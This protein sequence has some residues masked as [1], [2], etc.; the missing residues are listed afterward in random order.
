[1]RLEK[2]DRFPTWEELK[3]QARERNQDEE[4]CNMKFTINAGCLSGADTILATIKQDVKFRY[5]KQRSR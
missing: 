5:L 1:M 3:A 2:V 4:L